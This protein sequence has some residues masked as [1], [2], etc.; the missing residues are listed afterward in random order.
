MLH[1]CNDAYGHSVLL[2]SLECEGGGTCTSY[3]SGMDD[4]ILL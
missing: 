4:A 1:G 3:R 2:R